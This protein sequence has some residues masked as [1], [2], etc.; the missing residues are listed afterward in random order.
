MHKFYSF[1]F[2]QIVFVKNDEWVSYL[3]Q[4]VMKI[5]LFP[6]LWSNQIQQ[7]K[8]QQRMLNRLEHMEGSKVDASSCLEK[9]S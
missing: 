9:S 8:R 1:T 4:E 5:L 2:S 3:T 7:E 6:L